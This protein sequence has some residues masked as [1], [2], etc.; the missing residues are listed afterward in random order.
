MQERAFSPEGNLPLAPGSSPVIT[1]MNWKGSVSL[2]NGGEEKSQEDV[3]LRGAGVSPPSAQ[4]ALFKSSSEGAGRHLRSA[5]YRQSDSY[6][7]ICPIYLTP[8]SA[9]VQEK[10]LAAHRVQPAACEVSRHRQVAATGGGGPQ[11]EDWSKGKKVAGENRGEVICEGR[12]PPGPSSGNSQ[13]SLKLSSC[14]VEE[15]K[16]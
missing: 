3:C 5:R 2:E 15:R 1:R 12:P 9:C 4:R 11:C 10:L 16:R 7:E 6:R 13:R 8:E 14:I